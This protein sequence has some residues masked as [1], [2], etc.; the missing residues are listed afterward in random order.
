MYDISLVCHGFQSTAELPRQQ[1]D[2]LLI[3]VFH[4]SLLSN[5]GV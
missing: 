2:Q 1:N 5:R 3:H 4:V